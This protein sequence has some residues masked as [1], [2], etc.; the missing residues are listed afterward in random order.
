MKIVEP[1]LG[2]VAV[3]SMI[4][5]L[6]DVPATRSILVFS[7][8]ILS[9]IYFYLSF[10]LF[11]GIRLREIFKKKSYIEISTLKI[12]VAIFT[13]I[14]LSIVTM[15]LLFKYQEYPGGTQFIVIGLAG[16]IVIFTIAIVKYK[17]TKSEYYLKIL[18]RAIF[19]GVIGLSLILIPKETWLELR[20]KNHP[21]YID[22]QKKSWA[23]PENREL[24]IR[25]EKE[26]M[27]T[28]EKE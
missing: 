23:D 3:L 27:K 6:V 8:T 9:L 14:V 21:E 16:L 11:N 2:I 18:S 26:R 13:G 24:R 22:I 7:L 4:L 5:N 1:I 12:I 19:Y 15:G 28:Y 10:A 25:A 20:F 17:K